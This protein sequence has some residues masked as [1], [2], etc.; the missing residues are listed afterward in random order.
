MK[1]S[2]I[3]ISEYFLTGGYMNKKIAVL[4]KGVTKK[5]VLMRTCCHTGTANIRV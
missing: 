2:I 1:C 3:F 4:K 5:D